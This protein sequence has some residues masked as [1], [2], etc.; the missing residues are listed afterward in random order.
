MGM[1]DEGVEYA[2]AFGS[3]RVGYV[4]ANGVPRTEAGKPLISSPC[5]YD[6]W[7]DGK[8]QNGRIPGKRAGTTKQ[9]PTCKGQGRM[10]QTY[11][12]ATS[13]DVMEYTGGLEKW[14]Q[15]LI[16]IGLHRDGRLQDRV[17]EVDE[18]DKDGL[19]QLAE[20]AFQAG[21][22]AVK[23]QKGTD[24]HKLSEYVDRGWDF[25]PTLRD[26][27][28][29][30]TPISYQDRADMAAWRRATIEQ[31]LTFE[32][33]EKFVVVDDLKVAGTADRLARWERT[34]CTCGGLTVIDLKTGRMDFGGGKMTQQLALYAHG[35]GYDPQTTQ[36]TDLG[37]C[38][39]V[40]LVVNIRAG[41]GVATY[42]QLDLVA[43]WEYVQLNVRVR[44]YRN[45]C[46]SSIKEIEA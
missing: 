15:R 14:R 37:L 21:D 43:G 25:P 7:T 23:A 31:G 36:R 35:R 18:D 12:R 22:G 4:D 40:G 44:E 3:L 46:K 20:D 28:G 2:D 27:N 10:L 8:C 16:L 41:E 1:F 26:D 17:L 11:T 6:G 29:V 34:P 38:P 19:S 13:H 42:H 45:A 39:H 9:C 33:I 32:A 24:L 5:P 30:E